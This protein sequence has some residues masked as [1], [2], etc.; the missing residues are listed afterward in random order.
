MV[1]QAF[2]DAIDQAV[3]DQ[4]LKV[5][6]R[7]DL[8]KIEKIPIFDFI[9]RKWVT[10]VEPVSMIDLNMAKF[11]DGLQFQSIILLYFHISLVTFHLLTLSPLEG[12]KSQINNVLDS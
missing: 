5:E 6:N 10:Y 3:L 1:H 9:A 2:D 12:L 8:K 4:I 11:C 7:L